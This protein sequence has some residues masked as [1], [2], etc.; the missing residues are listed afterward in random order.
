MWLDIEPLIQELVSCDAYDHNL[1]DD[2]GEVLL[3][4]GGTG[5]KGKRFHHNINTFLEEHQLGLEEIVFLAPEKQ[6]EHMRNK[7]LMPDDL[8]RKVKEDYR[9]LY[10]SGKWP[11]ANSMKHLAGAL[12]TANATPTTIQPPI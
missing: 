10:N 11:P 7:K 8:F 1:T 2:L 12:S 4:S 9:K 6:L 5:P 3:T